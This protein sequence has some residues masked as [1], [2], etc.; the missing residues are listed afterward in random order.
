MFSATIVAVILWILV[1][2][3]WFY[4]IHRELAERKRALQNSNNVKQK[5]GK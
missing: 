2:C 3:A 4:T 5:A 1:A